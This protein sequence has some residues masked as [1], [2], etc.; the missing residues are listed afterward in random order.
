MR[1]S[2]SARVVIVGGGVIGCAIARA[3]VVRGVDGVVVVEANPDVGEGASKANSA[4]VHTGFDARPGTTEARMLRAASPR[5]PALADELGVPFVSVGAVMLARS[6]AEEDHLRSSVGPLAEAHGVRA[7][8]LDEAALRDQVPY[9]SADARLG[10]AIPNESIVDPFWLTRAFAEAAITGGATIARDSRVVG[11]RSTDDGIDVT[12]EDGSVVRADQVVD[13][14]GLAAADVAGMLG[15]SSFRITPRKGQFLVSEETFGVDRIVL[16]VPG[17]MGKGM[18]VTPIVFGGILLGPT[19]VDIDEPDDRSTDPAEA[20]RIIASCTTLVPA[21]VDALPVRSFAGLRPVP[22]TGDHIV[23]PSRVTD[24][25]WLA[26]GIR[27]TGI[28]ASPA[29]AE[30][31]ADGVIAARGWHASTKPRI[32]PTPP[33]IAFA[34]D[35]GDLICLCRGVSEAE[36]D[37]A[38]D[39]PLPPTTIDG[40]KRRCGVTFGDCQGNL[41]TVAVAAWLADRLDVDITTIRKG[42]R[43]SWLFADRRAVQ[44]A[45]HAEV[46]RDGLGEAGPADVVVVGGGHA[47]R[48]AAAVLR[49]ARLAVTVVERAARTT[50]VGCVP[51]GDTWEVE[52]RS[53]GG[54]RTIDARAVLMTTGAYYR[55]REH[56]GIPGPR[57]AG[58]VTADF[59]AAAG[60]GGLVPGRRA[61]LVTVGDGGATTA[62]A[63]LETAGVEVVEDSVRR[64]DEIRGLERLEAVR[65]GD[66]WVEAD[67]LVLADRLLPQTFLLRGLG[68][69]DGRPGCPAPVD[70]SGRTP[71]AGLWAAGCCVDPDASH[72]RCV[73]HG[74]TAA[75]AIVRALRGDRR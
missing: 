61:V 50:A 3:L 32:F 9:V 26:C 29:I 30:A 21:I 72:E 5:W 71:M 74:R 23:G 37:A 35:P 1:P 36:L 53:P 25:L 62:V 16:P 68:L 73:S 57:P 41:C 45:G 12:L 7:E 13:A 59:V 8:W 69:V 47:G 24:R 28:S 64:P 10:L 70:G 40:L 51:V 34:D 15:D 54:A 75:E 60:A 22:S 46:S 65:F 42:P 58:V 11:L 56:G 31:V 33:Q 49:A 4:I 67:L 55:P 43:G 39:R 38:Y 44:P 20:A 17:P 52:I 6:P 14:A 48:A 66:R 2:D 19:A 27:S 63:G 18:L